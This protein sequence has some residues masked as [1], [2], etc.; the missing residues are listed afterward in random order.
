MSS[1][2][3]FEAESP[4]NRYASTA[5]LPDGLTPTQE[6]AIRLLIAKAWR[7]GYKSRRAAMLEEA[8][9]LRREAALLTYA[10]N[11]RHSCSTDYLQLSKHYSCQ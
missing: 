9:Q 1:Q 8:K 6:R 4:E 2:D 7:E 11:L 3:D 10:Y 5:V